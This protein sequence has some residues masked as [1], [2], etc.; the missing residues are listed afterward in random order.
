MDT[1]IR[2]DTG[3]APAKWTFDDK[4]T[5]VFD[6]MLERSIPQ[7]PVMRDACFALAC[8][9]RQ[10]QTAILDLGCSRGEA[11]ARLIDKFGAHNRY[12]GI[13]ASLPMVEACRTRFKGLIDVSVAEIRHADLRT[14]FPPIQASVILSILTIQFIALEYRAAILKHVYDELLPYGAFL[15]VEKILG[16]SHDLDTAMV[17]EYYALKR[18]NGYSQEEI[19][20]KRLSLEGVMTPVTAKWNEDLLRN[21]GFQEIDCFWRWQNFAGWVAIKR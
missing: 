1:L 3:Y 12:V 16:A 14:N 19:D 17:T 11:L 13:D 20:R 21:A 10:P 5:A 6:N 8:R 15:F 18:A 9:Y 7:Y 2:H 4:V